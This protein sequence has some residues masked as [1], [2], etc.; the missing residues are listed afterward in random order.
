VGSKCLGRGEKEAEW[1]PFHASR[2]PGNSHCTPTNPDKNQPVPPVKPAVP[3]V[4]TAPVQQP[5][6][7]ATAQPVP[8]AK[9]APAQPHKP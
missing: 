7:T 2:A 6:K 1:L 5:V 4:K 9:T 8:P 3:P